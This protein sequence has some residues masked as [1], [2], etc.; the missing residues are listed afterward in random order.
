MAHSI[1][2]FG[3]SAVRHP[4]LDDFRVRWRHDRRAAQ[5]PD[6]LVGALDHHMALVGVRP[7]HFAGPGQAK[8]LLDPGFGLQLGHLALLGPRRCASAIRRPVL[9]MRAGWS[10]SPP[11]RQPLAGRGRLALWQMRPLLATAEPRWPLARG[12]HHDHLAAFEFRLL[13]DL[14]QRGEVAAD[15]LEQLAAE[16]LVGELPAAEAQGDLDLV[17]LLEEPP[18]RAH[19]HVV[20]VIVNHGPELDLLDLDDLLLFARLG[21]L[22][23]LLVLEFAVV[24]DFADRGGLVGD[25]LDEVQPRFGGDGERVADR[26]DAVVLSLLIDQLH[27]ADANLII[28]ARAV[29]LNGQR[30]FHRATNGEDLLCL[31][32]RAVSRVPARMRAPASSTTWPGEDREKRRRSQRRSG[33]DAKTCP[34]A[35]RGPRR[36][37]QMR[38]VP[39][40]ARAS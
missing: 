31:L 18:D 15:A 22:L 27:L 10:T 23:L 26:H 1:E 30:G 36:Q 25:D 14:G 7:Q 17:A 4:F 40:K 39:Q 32:R 9:N 35:L 37:A 6:L 11:P 38:R 19:F 12:E 34:T 29:L 2:N 5:L 16:L 24:E 20:I 21:G 13:L 28:D 33:H 3:R 8:A